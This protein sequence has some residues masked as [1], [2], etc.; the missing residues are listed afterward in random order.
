[1]FRS[2]K[3][4][5]HLWSPLC[6]STNILVKN[7]FARILNIF[8]QDETWM[9]GL[10]SVTARCFGCHV[11]FFF[12]FFG[13][14]SWRKSPGQSC[15]LLLPECSALPTL[16]TLHFTWHLFWL[17]FYS[18][19][20]LDVSSSSSP[21]PICPVKITQEFNVVWCDNYRRPRSNP[22][23][24]PVEAR[25]NIAGCLVGLY[26]QPLPNKRPLLQ[27]DS[28]FLSVSKGVCWSKSG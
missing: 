23:L 10:G 22:P 12:F 9:A 21:K 7:H 24:R 14:Y 18:P 11:F 26:P 19:Q 2:Q 28:Y 25:V 4:T 15:W 16:P 27:T 5:S 13:V 20:T 1:M 6:R 3:I 8:Y 17:R